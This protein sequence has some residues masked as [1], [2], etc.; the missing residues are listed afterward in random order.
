M[1][2]QE[3]QTRT[4][5]SEFRDLS[6]IDESGPDNNEFFSISIERQGWENF[7]PTANIHV[8]R[9]T[10][11]WIGLFVMMRSSQWYSVNIG[12]NKGELLEEARIRD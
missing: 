5:D 1:K 7:H 2:S 10:G 12:I 3:M 9:W 8:D 4:E 6:E 11:S